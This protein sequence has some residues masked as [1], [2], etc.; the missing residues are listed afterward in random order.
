M[1]LFSTVFAPVVTLSSSFYHYL[2]LS[3]KSVRRFV[4][5]FTT[6][7]Q[8]FSYVVLIEQVERQGN[9][10]YGFADA[11][12]VESLVDIRMTVQASRGKPLTTPIRRSELLLFAFAGNVL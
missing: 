9:G 12:T 1:L 2:L 10:D 3:A 6:P 8:L 7:S 11:R 5:R 4:C